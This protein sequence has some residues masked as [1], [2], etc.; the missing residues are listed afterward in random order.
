MFYDIP[1]VVNMIAARQLGFLG[2]IVWGPHDSPAHRMLTACCQ[3]KRKRGCPYLH[4]KDVI[5]QNLCLLF[6]RIPK[7]VNNGYGSVKDWFK[8]ASHESYWTALVRFL[9]D[10][11]APLPAQPT[12]WPTP[13][14]RSPRGH[15]SSPSPPSDTDAPHD[16]YN[17][18]QN[19]SADSPPV[20]SPPRWCPPP[21]PSISQ[22]TSYQDRLQPWNGQPKPRTFIQSI[23]SWARRHGNRSQ[24]EILCPCM[25]L[26]PQ[27][28]WRCQNRN[29]ISNSCWL[30]QAH[31]QRPSLLMQSPMTSLSQTEKPMEKPMQDHI[32]QNYI[33]YTNNKKAKW[34]SLLHHLHTLTTTLHNPIIKPLYW[35]MKH[36]YLSHPTPSPPATLEMCIYIDGFTNSD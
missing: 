20:P 6:A 8:E 2:K 31:Q 15:S 14:W 9:L 21:P 3:H 7:V 30:L 26:P 10:K 35:W 18:R 5:V 22:L 29:D 1:Y 28:A 11:Q 33:T 4:N 27:Q 19:D 12:T 24:G 16:N 36:A 17:K 34:L 32:I 25:N 13:L 23:R